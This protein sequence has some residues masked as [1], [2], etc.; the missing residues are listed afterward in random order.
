MF[1]RDL[2]IEHMIINISQF[3][4]IILIKAEKYREQLLQQIQEITIK[5]VT[6]QKMN[7]KNNIATYQKLTY[8]SKTLQSE[9]IRKNHEISTNKHFEI[10]KIMK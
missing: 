3:I 8:I 6:I 10:N 1:K 4:N 9:I 5:N 7:Q 2:K